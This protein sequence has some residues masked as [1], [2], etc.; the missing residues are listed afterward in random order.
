MFRSATAAAPRALCLGAILTC[1]SCG[2]ATPEPSAASSEQ[3]PADPV[4]ETT[5]DDADDA[6]ESEGTAANGEDAG[7]DEDE[8]EAD[9]DEDEDAS[10]PNA[11]REKV[12]SKGV[13]SLSVTIDGVV[14]DVRAKPKRAAGGW[15]VTLTLEAEAES[16]ATRF[17]LSP[18]GGP[19]AFHAEVRKL[20]NKTGEPLAKR[21]D[22]REGDG[23]QT[24]APEYPLKLERDWPRKGE[25][26]LYGNQE[27]TL[28]VGLWGLGREPKQ[29]RPVKKFVIVKMVYAGGRT[30]KAYV[31]PPD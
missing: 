15:G 12:Y 20:G 28:Q 31:N 3:P 23:E 7:E 29:T 19:L 8:D 18:E 9:E 14:F 30:P 6:D 13:Q 25:K 2:G 26:P 1:V 4:S 5:S 10:D 24:V 11:P 27:L 17:L 21:G 16:D 22:A